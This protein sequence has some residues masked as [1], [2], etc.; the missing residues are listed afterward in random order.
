MNNLE[1]RGK[2]KEREFYQGLLGEATDSGNLL[3]RHRTVSY[4]YE[5]C[6]DRNGHVNTFH[7]NPWHS[8]S[9]LNL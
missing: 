5:S 3:E 1:V 7:P 6:K 9:W 2:R 4:G 8:S